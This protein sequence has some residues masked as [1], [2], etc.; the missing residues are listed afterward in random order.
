MDIVVY[1]YGIYKEIYV[2][3]NVLKVNIITQTHAQTVQIDVYNVSLNIIV[4][5]AK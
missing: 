2:F 5:S 4:F 1:V 3:N